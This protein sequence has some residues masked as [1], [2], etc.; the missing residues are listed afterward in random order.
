MIVDDPQRRPSQDDRSAF[1]QQ[2][3]PPPQQGLPL[4]QL[5]IRP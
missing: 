3:A 5:P 1:P 4:P 2:Q